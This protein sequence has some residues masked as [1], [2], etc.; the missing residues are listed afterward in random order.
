VNFELY[1]RV[2]LMADTGVR[3]TEACNLKWTDID[4]QNLLI[5]VMGKGRK[6]R[7]IPFSPALRKYRFECLRVSHRQ[8]GGVT[9][10][11]LPPLG[12]GSATGANG[13]S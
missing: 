11:Q 8:S 12:T 2:L 3:V 13:T 9:Y 10:A 4:L 5:V 6:S 7:T 1:R